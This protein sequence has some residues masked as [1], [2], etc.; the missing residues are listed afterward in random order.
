M[1]VIQMVAFFLHENQIKFNQSKYQFINPIYYLYFDEENK[2]KEVEKIYLFDFEATNKEIHESVS[3]I[4]QNEIYEITLD[5]NDQNEVI[6][7]GFK[8]SL[9]I[10]NTKQ[11]STLL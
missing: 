11:Y 10:D 4:F 1:S 8:Y 9:E 2:L 6:K 5:N 3:T 7:N